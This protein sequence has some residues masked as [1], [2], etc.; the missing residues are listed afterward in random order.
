MERAA[1]ITLGLLVQMM[2]QN[3]RLC[4]LAAG[5][6]VVSN[7]H[8]LMGVFG[9]FLRISTIRFTRVL[10]PEMV[11]KCLGSIDCMSDIIIAFIH[12]IHG[13]AI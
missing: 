12:R 7:L 9:F 3:Q 1:A 8:L 11:A 10:V 5:T 2:D 13:I 6:K 4:T